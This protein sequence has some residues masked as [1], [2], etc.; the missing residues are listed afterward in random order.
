MFLAFYNIF[1]IS[2]LL[3]EDCMKTNSF[4]HCQNMII[5]SV[6]PFIYHPQ[7]IFWLPLFTYNSAATVRVGKIELE[8]WKPKVPIIHIF[9]CVISLILRMT[10]PTCPVSISGD[11]NVCVCGLIRS[12]DNSGPVKGILVPRVNRHQPSFTEDLPDTTPLKTTHI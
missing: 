10:Q 12:W 7:E 2:S 6:N 4:C 1:S 3:P 11:R 5:F 8:D 9:A